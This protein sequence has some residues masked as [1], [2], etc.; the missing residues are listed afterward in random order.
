MAATHKAAGAFRDAKR[1][2][3]KMRR[4]CA[5]P[6]GGVR[7]TVAA[8]GQIERVGSRGNLEKRKNQRK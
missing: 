6:G 1:G 7:P 4:P 3:L 2:E 8:A 5:S